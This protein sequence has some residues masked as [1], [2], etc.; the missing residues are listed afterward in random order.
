M[1]LFIIKFV[2]GK[3]G[4]TSLNQSFVGL[5]KSEIAMDLGPDRGCGL[6]RSILFPVSTGQGPVQSRSFSGP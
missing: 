4:E 6:F 3:T 1:G 2:D 5:C